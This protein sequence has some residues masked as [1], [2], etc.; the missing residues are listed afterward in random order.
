MDVIS[1]AVEAVRSEAPGIFFK[2]DEPVKNYTTFKIGGPA[3]VMFFPESINGLTEVCDILNRHD[4]TPAILGNGS[5]IL[6]SDA[7]L[8]IVIINMSGLNS[9]EPADTRDTAMQEHWDIRADAGVLL[10]QLAVFACENGLT[11]LEFAH[12]IPGSLGG[13]VVMNAGAYGGEMKDV[14]YSTVVYNAADGK[15]AIPAAGHE[16]TYRSSRFTGSNDI[17]F[18]SVIR[19]EKGDRESIKRRMEELNARRR[20][21]QPLDLPSGGS[22]FKRPKD[23]Y[24]A[25]LIEQAG[26][27]GYSSGGAQVSDK[28]AGFIVNRGDAKFTDVMA[29]IGHVQETVL[30]KLGVSLELE[31]KVLK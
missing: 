1:R 27:K 20:E 23:G 6:A 22:T 19:L 3:R 8:N 11:G 14:I 9:I 7:K 13:A 18:S 4:I 10:S 31:V 24:A 2:L 12:G 17:L 16:F 5:N 15:C 28:H 25:A 30:K 21:S 26:L 29:V